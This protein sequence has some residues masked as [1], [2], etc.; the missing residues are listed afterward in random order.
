[1]IQAYFTCTEEE[2]KSIEAFHREV[3][4]VSNSG[5]ITY[6]CSTGMKCYSKSRLKYHA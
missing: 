4:G 1:M 6:Q 3:F 2:E 5:M